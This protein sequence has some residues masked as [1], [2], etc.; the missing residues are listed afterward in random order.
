MFKRI[1]DIVSSVLV[2]LII[3]PLMIL[4]AI[5]V[6][7]SGKGRIFFVQKR[8]GRHGL[9]FNLYKFRTMQINSEAL[10]QLTIGG[11]DPRVT[12]IGYWLRKFKLDELPQLFNVIGGS[13]SVV[14]PR[15]EVI[16]YTSLYSNEQKQVLNVRPGL[17]DYASL[18]YIAEDELLGKASDP[19]KT[20]INEV[21]PAKLALNLKYIKEQSFLT[22][23]KIIFRTIGKLFS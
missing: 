1:F 15:P 20:Y 4:I 3:W 2:L 14:G 18:V 17:T 19:F 21:M 10:G 11:K 12:R 13:M 8:V 7:C 9:E 23:L 5:L 16:R 6:L 22:D